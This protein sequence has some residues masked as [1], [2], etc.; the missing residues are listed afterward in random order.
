MQYVPNFGELCGPDARR[1][2]IHVPV[3]PVVA[4]G[5]L[6]PGWRVGVSNGRAYTTGVDVIGIVD[7][8]L[9]EPVRE[10]ETFWLFLFSERS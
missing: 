3:A 6:L 10:G 2:A 4:S 8:F 1:D 7:P 9:T 5:V